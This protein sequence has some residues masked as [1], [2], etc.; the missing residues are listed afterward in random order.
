MLSAEFIVNENILPAGAPF[1]VEIALSRVRR[2]DREVAVA[3]GTGIDGAARAAGLAAASAT[4][5]C[6][7]A[8]G[9]SPRASAA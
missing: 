5:G 8:R 6:A 3:V 1:D 4:G 9:A 7:S 2:S